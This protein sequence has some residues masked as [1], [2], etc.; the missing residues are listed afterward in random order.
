MNFVIE[1]PDSYLCEVRAQ[2]LVHVCSTWDTVRD[3]PVQNEV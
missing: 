3:E 1:T 2:Q